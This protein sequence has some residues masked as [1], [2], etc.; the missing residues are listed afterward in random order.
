LKQ[1]RAAGVAIV[2]D[3]E[4]LMLTAPAPPPASVITTLAQHKAEVLALLRPG[5]CGWSAEDWLAFFE[6]RAGIAAF[7]ARLP[8]GAAEARAFACC[9]A[10]WLIRHPVRS[11]AGRC[12]HC[13]GD[14]QT[15]NPLLPHGIEPPGLVW[16]HSRCWTAWHVGR[17]A[18]VMTALLKLGLALPAS[19][20][21]DFGKIGSR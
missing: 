8:R 19:L 11:P 14:H 12:L 20:P 15:D 9:V 2:P 6:E 21:D 7:E 3:G 18:E 17:K 1:A 4:D 10:E 13:G 16:L 5:T